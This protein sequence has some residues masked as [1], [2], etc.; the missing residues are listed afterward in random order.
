MLSFQHFIGA[1]MGA[2]LLVAANARVDQDAAPNVQLTT[3]MSKYSQ[4]IYHVMS[5]SDN[6][7]VDGVPHFFAETPAGTEVLILTS[8]DPQGKDMITVCF[9][10][11]DEAADWL[12]NFNIILDPFGPRNKPVSGSMKVHGGFNDGIF[13]HNLYDGVKKTIKHLM[14]DPTMDFGKRVYFTGHSQGGALAQVSGAY[15]AHQHP[16][17]DV[18]VINFGAPR[19]GNKSF[20]AWAESR[21]NL[22]M[23]RFCYENDIVPRLAPGMEHVGHLLQMDDSR[24]RGYY[25]QTGGGNYLGVPRAWAASISVADHYPL[26]YLQYFELKSMRQPSAYYFNGFEEKAKVCIPP[27][28]WEFWKK[29]C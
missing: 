8:T 12:T 20:K 14:S 24:A 19:L 11:S 15:F 13:E 23:W 18:Y 1:L 21:S 4:M 10:G 3:K 26:K 28:W 7:I 25:R 29:R 5:T 6:D 9:R 16:H 2:L 27:K 17:I 22:C